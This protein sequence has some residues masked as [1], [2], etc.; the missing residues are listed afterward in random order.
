MYFHRTSTRP[1][2]DGSLPY[3]FV[4]AQPSSVSLR[5][6]CRESLLRV[7]YL[8]V[9]AQPSSVSLRLCSRESLLHPDRLVRDVPRLPP[10]N[11]APQQEAANAS[12][13][14]EEGSGSSSSGEEDGSGSSSEEEDE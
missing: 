12:S 11:F 10:R 2:M 8:F 4:L 1:T 3:L 6:C 9:L 13:S 7:P 5:L 14:E